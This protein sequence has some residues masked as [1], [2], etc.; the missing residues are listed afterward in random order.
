MT[1]RPDGRADSYGSAPAGGQL[2]AGGLIDRHRNHVNEMLES[3]FGAVASF[4]LVA[5]RGRWPKRHGGGVVRWVDKSGAR[6][7]PGRDVARTC[8]GGLSRGPTVNHSFTFAC[9]HPGVGPRRARW[10]LREGKAGSAEERRYADASRAM[11]RFLALSM[12]DR[13]LDFPRSTYRHSTQRKRYSLRRF[14]QRVN[15]PAYS[16]PLRPTLS[17][18]F[19]M[20]KRWTNTYASSV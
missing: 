9:D 19:S 11:R 12:G 4:R 8:F 3:R 18:P 14:W 7:V 10:R 13:P 16:G 1:V 5:A 17:K 2:V 15:S 6:A 20:L